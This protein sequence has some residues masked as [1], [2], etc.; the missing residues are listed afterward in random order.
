MVAIT[1]IKMSQ[2]PK[3]LNEVNTSGASLN[4]KLVEIQKSDSISQ[5][6]LVLRDYFAL[7]GGELLSIKFCDTMNEADTIRPYT[8]YPPAVMKI[9]T[10]LGMTGGCPFAKES[11][12]LMRPI[13]IREIDRARYNTEME[14]R[15]LDEVEE[16]GHTDLAVLPVLIGRGMAMATVGLFDRNFE[17]QL[18][19]EISDAVP[20]LLAAFTSRFPEVAILFNRKMLGNRE[21]EIIQMLCEGHSEMEISAALQLSTHTL[22]LLVKNAS[23]KLKASNTPQLVYRCLVLGEISDIKT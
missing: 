10:V 21:R 3:L 11:L 15:F 18:R 7:L 2:L 17:G 13:S 8:N 6:C 16:L 14:T 4:D 12:R 20:R 5:A 23:K 19:A 1:G 9:G 22:R